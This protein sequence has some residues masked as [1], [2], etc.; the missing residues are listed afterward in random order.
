MK[1]SLASWA[2]RCSFKG[3]LN[4]PAAAWYSNASAAKA[5]GPRIRA[6]I[7][8]PPGSG[9]G[10]I[11]SR[12]VKRFDMTHLSSGDL[13]RNQLTKRTPA[14]VAAKSYMEAGVL[15]PD[16]VM[17]ELILAE[18]R[19]TPPEKGWLLD[20]FP[21]TVTQT[22]EL[23]KHQSLDTVINLDVP[24]ATIIERI[25]GRWTHIPSGRV[26]NDSYN[27]PRV[28]G[29]DDVTGE[30]LAQRPDDHPDTVLK[31]LQQYETMTKPVLAYYA[32]AGF[33]KIF[34]GTESDKICPEVVLFIKST[35]CIMSH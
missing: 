3:Q 18:I 5:T 27:P 12:L 8:G 4:T 19:A 9:K 6:M 13:L 14:G 25:R 24:F 10:T 22:G 21:R 17:V 33:L 7:M 16:D 23:W 29:R 35:F 32:R 26:Y 20:G 30:P 34:R 1:T 2:A 31:R 11:S 15:V 28:P